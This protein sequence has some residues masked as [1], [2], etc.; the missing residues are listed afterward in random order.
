MRI[1]NIIAVLLIFLLLPVCAGTAIA[2]ED[3]EISFKAACDSYLRKGAA[4]A[5]INYSDSATTMIIDGRNSAERIGI[6]R[7]VYGTENGEDI[8]ILQSEANQISLK[9][10]L[11]ANTGNASMLIYGLTDETMKTGWTNEGITYNSA[12]ALGILPISAQ[13]T[14][15]VPLLGQYSLEGV[16]VGQYIYVDV[17]EYVKAEAAKVS[18][19]GTDGTFVFLIAGADCYTAN[20]LFRISADSEANTDVSIIPE[21]IA[22]NGDGGYAL[23]DRIN[24]K[25]DKTYQVTED[26]ILPKTLGGERDAG[27]VSSVSWSS[28]TPN[29]ISIADNVN[30]YTARVVRPMSSAVSDAVVTLTATIK[31]G[32]AT[33]TKKFTLNV[34]PNGVFNSVSTA[35]ISNSSSSSKAASN[36]NTVL[37]TQAN[38][39][40]KMIAFVSFDVSQS[41]C[42]YASKMMLRLKPNY[43]TGSFNVK[44]TPVKGDLANSFSENITWNTGADYI[45]AVNDDYAAFEQSPTSAEWVEI[46]VTEY[47]KA[48]QSKALF[49]LEITSDINSSAIFYGNAMKYIPQLKIYNYETVSDPEAAVSLVAAQIQNAITAMQG[50]LSGITGDITLPTSSDYGVEVIWQALGSDGQPSQ[51]LG[52]DGTVIAFPLTDAED[53][54][55]VLKLTITR[56]DYDGAMTKDYAAK[57]LRQLTGGEAVLYTYDKLTLEVPVLT[58]GGMLPSG[59]FG[60]DIT[61]RA[62]TADAASQ[63]SGI[64][65][66]GGGYTVFNRANSVEVP[67]LLEA[68]IT[69]DGYDGQPLVKT[70]PA[71][72]LRSAENDLLNGRIILNAAAGSEYNTNDD[73]AATYYSVS[74]GT[75]SLTYSLT[76]QS[77]VGTV[78]LYPYAADNIGA[79]TIET[80]TADGEWRSAYRAAAAIEGL[81]VIAL[82]NSENTKQLR[83]TL[84]GKTLEDEIGIRHISAYSLGDGNADIGLSA[85]EIIN[86]ANFK[87][88]ANIPTGAV[89]KDFTL[90]GSVNE[91][92]VS[93][94]SS[95]S[96]VIR[97]IA[98]GGVTEAIIT[99]PS[100]TTSVVITATVTDESGF[101]ASKSF[102]VTVTGT[103]TITGG[104][105]SIGGGGVY[106]PSTTAGL[107]PVNDGIQQQAVSFTDLSEA[108]WAERYILA[109]AQKGIISGKGEGVFEPN[110]AVKREEFIKILV[111]ALEIELQEGV[112]SF[113]DVPAE[114]WAQGYILAAEKCGITNGIGDG[115][116]GLGLD[117][118]REDM[119]VM[120]CRALRQLGYTLGQ[121]LDAVLFEDHN[122]I[123]DYAL[124]HVEYLQRAGVL[125]GSANRIKP[126]APA[127]R[128]ET[129]KTIYE[130]IDKINQSQSA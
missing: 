106:A 51:Y 10:R 98:S 116:F 21:L 14:A 123:S 30:S 90:N 12:T 25:I 58:G 127:T 40:T 24:L 121:P 115:S 20:D 109:L 63:F 1:K 22:Q 49:K 118:S 45:N 72:I 26:F 16:S 41:A 2:S 105:G 69:A 110:S 120:I 130:I 52:S 56:G 103:Q 47:V 57:V 11:G 9:L 36:P 7:F 125:S 119:A 74:S 126:L 96:S 79:V 76:S 99:R 50:T 113:S 87:T 68:S 89:T 48:Q 108:A 129:A 78:I 31:N 8:G 17:T 112:C 27:T 6:V 67:I 95:N 77:N 88:L 42:R 43:M 66:V 97:L 114:H 61:W 55:V 37:Y 19:A 34:M 91:L 107:A 46:D 92:E 15:Q 29:V 4:N 28:D 39:T 23:K 13:G 60:T 104:V 54:A 85:Q 111:G 38:G 33:E 59:Y 18:Q 94:T 32:T 102:T 117:I 44:I 62:L 122:V 53:S 100:A 64:A 101:T 5:D 73:N 93:Y 35:Y 124:E 80:K 82:A 83:V 81:N 3:F 71:T 84:S 70:F 75:L 128:A 86:N 65:F